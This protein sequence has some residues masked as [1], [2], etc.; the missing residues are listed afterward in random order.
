L[1]KA[2]DRESSFFWTKGTHSGFSLRGNGR[3]RTARSARTGNLPQGML[4]R[5]KP[6]GG[7]KI[8]K[9]SE[10]CLAFSGVDRILNNPLSKKF[11]LY[12][13]SMQPTAAVNGEWLIAR[14]AGA[15]HRLVNR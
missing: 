1:Q 13:V 6:S 11:T 2:K 5:G 15:L 7:T 8:I 14:Q 4:F 3:K 12:A 9:I 10:N